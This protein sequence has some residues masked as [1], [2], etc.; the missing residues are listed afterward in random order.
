MQHRRGRVRARVMS[1]KLTMSNWRRPRGIR[2]FPESLWHPR[3]RWYLSTN[4]TMLSIEIGA[5]IALQVKEFVTCI[6]VRP[7]TTVIPSSVWTTRS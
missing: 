1:W 5:N 3:R 7:R 4:F 6:G 2:G